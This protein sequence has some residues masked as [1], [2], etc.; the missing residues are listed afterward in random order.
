[1]VRPMKFLARYSE[2]AYLLLRVLAS[3][4]FMVHGVQKMFG[5]LGGKV[6]AVGTQI[7]FGGAIELIC[8]ALIALGLFTRPAAFLAAGTMAV[9]YIQ[10][11]WKLDL[12]RN[13]WPVINKGELAAVYALLF[14]NIACAGPGRFSLDHA[15]GQRG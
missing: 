5:V 15:R 13:F 8:G 7:W 10:F 3:L 14:L 6:P 12:G 11:H 9:A 1:M 4:M 2:I